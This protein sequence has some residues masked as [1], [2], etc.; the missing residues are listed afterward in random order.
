MNSFLMAAGLLALIERLSVTL[1][2]LDGLLNS[3][4]DRPLDSY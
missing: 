2:A 3:Q 4:W 1:P